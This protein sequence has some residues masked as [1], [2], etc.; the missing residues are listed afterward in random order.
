MVDEK[1]SWCIVCMGDDC[2]WWVYEA[3]D[4]INFDTESS[5]ILDPKQVEHMIDMLSQLKQYGLS[6]EIVNGAFIPYSIDKEMPKEMLRLCESK[7]NILMSHDGI[8]CMP[9]V[10]DEQEGPFID[11]IDHIMALRVKLLNSSF[12]FKQPLNLEEIEDILHADQQERYIA[13]VKMHAFD[14]I[15]SILDYVPAGYKLGGDMDE[16]QEQEDDLDILPFDDSEGADRIG[17]G[18]KDWN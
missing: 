5:G 3:S 17:V 6:E 10:V 11:F 16:D 18:G 7:R 14:E 8:F 4:E 13:G 9:N 15:V 12:D 1:G 2:N